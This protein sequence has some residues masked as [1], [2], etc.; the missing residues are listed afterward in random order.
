MCIVHQNIY[1]WQILLD[2]D[3]FY[4]N[5]L[6]PKSMENQ[7]QHKI[8]QKKMI[9]LSKIPQKILIALG[10]WDDIEVILVKVS[11]Q[12]HQP[13]L[14]YVWTPCDCIPLVLNE[15]WK[16][17]F[18]INFWNISYLSEITMLGSAFSP[19]IWCQW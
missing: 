12:M 7:S 18:G 10:A 13:C 11:K 1:I 5:L 4:K 15:K 2:F 16:H 3:D 6:I 14:L 8:S 17:D 9:R 19:R